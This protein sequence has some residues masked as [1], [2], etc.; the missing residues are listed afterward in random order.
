MPLA[1]CYLL[2]YLLALPFISLFNFGSAVVRSGGDTKRPMYCLIFAGIVNLLLNLLLVIVFNMSVVGVATA[3]LISNVVSSAMIVR[4]LLKEKGLLHLEIKNLHI[5]KEP[6]IKMIRSGV[7]AAL[8]TTVFSIANVTIQSGINAFGPAAIA[9][10]AAANNFE[11]F[12]YY[13]VNAF[14]QTAVTFV[15][16][17]FAAK[18]PER[19]KQILKVCMIESLIGVLLLE[20]FFY[21][22]RYSLIRIFTTQEA[23]IA[24]AMVRITCCTLPH[25]LMCSY[26]ITGSVLRGMGH[27]LLPAI[28]TLIGSV[29]FRVFWVV[30]V[31]KAWH[32]FHGLLIVYPLSWILTGIMVI[33]AYVVISKKELRTE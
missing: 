1:K 28:L 26:E 29:G 11:M 32:T 3:T 7:P 6:L 2:I 16:Q 9:G 8:Q 14:N 20:A 31:F 5:A 30:V 15:G 18:K 10:S 12:D 25:F 21:F 13:L 4:I 19:C 23:V 17:N 27:S 24:Y 22:G 33:T